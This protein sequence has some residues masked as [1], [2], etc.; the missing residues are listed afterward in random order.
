MNK[1]KVG[2]RVCVYQSDENSAFSC[3]GTVKEVN[4]R[5]LTVNPDHSTKVYRYHYKQCRKLVKKHCRE[6]WIDLYSSGGV[7]VHKSKDT[8][9]SI[10]TS[11]AE[12]I[13]VRE[14]K[15]K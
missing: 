13:H 14:V 5:S 11:A 7:T 6:F 1:F 10:G 12:R 3:R 4:P 2:D 9:E 15:K 8:L